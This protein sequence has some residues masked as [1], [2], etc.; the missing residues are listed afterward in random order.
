[1]SLRNRLGWQWIQRWWRKPVESA[2]SSLTEATVH[3]AYM[4]QSTLIVNNARL[5]HTDNE[6]AEQL[7]T[8]EC[9]GGKV[10]R[11]SLSDGSNDVVPLPDVHEIDAKGSLLLPSLCHS[12]IHL[13]KCFILDRCKCEI[14]DFTEAMRVTARAKQVFRDDPDDLLQRGRRL[15]RESIECGVTSM[16]AHVEVDFI[17]ELSCLATAVKLRNEF[18]TAC[19]IQ[20]AVFAQESL[21]DSPTD[22]TPGSNYHFLKQALEDPEVEA[23]GS[24]PYV[25]SNIAQAKKNITLILE[26][27]ARTGLHAD[28]HLDYNLDPSTE[29]LIWEVIREAKRIGMNRTGGITI[30]HATRLQLF[31]P[32]QWQELKEAIGKLPITLVSLPNSD[33]Y[34]QGREDRDKPLGPPRSTLRVPYIARKYDLQVA[35]S[36]NNIENAFTPQGSMDPLALC[37]LGVALFQSATPRDIRTLICSVTLTSKCALGIAPSDLPQD[38]FPQKGDPA[39]FVIIHGTQTLYQAVLNPSY[40]RTTIRGGVVVARRLTKK[41]VMCNQPRAV[42]ESVLPWYRRV[43]WSYMLFPPFLLYEFLIVFKAIDSMSLHEQCETD[44]SSV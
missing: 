40:D 1:M 28:F 19:N 25:E 3:Q 16:R 41:W 37:T 7:W 18:K 27:A 38:L 39:D 36:V 21:F 9:R 30:G 22:T 12:H 6:M 13:D 2:E 14:G 11:V 33:L 44:A 15:V 24:A 26:L 31:T 32:D 29:P 4:P 42:D 43:K 10:E 5:A 23:V 17:V 34:M 8:I 35:M 20:I